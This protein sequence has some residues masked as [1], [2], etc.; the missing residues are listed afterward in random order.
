MINSCVHY[1]LNN[2]NSSSYLIETRVNSEK[3]LT[4]FN[5]KILAECPKIAFNYL[6]SYLIKPRNEFYCKWNYIIAN[7]C[8]L[9]IDRW[10]L[11]Y[12]KFCL[13]KIFKMF[14]KSVYMKSSRGKPSIIKK[15]RTIKNNNIISIIQTSEQWRKTD[16]V[17]LGGKWSVGERIE[18]GFHGGKWQ[19]SPEY[20]NVVFLHNFVHC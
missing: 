6:Y 17:G 1:Y 9:S 20:K 3:M 2:V 11:R 7:Q 8:A 12:I 5:V 14:G 4:K 16:Y 19:R 15:L 10:L 13:L 18:W